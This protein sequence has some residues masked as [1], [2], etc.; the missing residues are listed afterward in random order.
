MSSN[1]TNVQPKSASSSKA[2]PFLAMFRCPWRY[3]LPEW[4]RTMSLKDKAVMGDKVGQLV[5]EGRVEDAIKHMQSFAG[6]QRH[7]LGGGRERKVANSD[8]CVV[9]ALAVVKVVEDVRR[10]RLPPAHRE[11]LPY[12]PLTSTFFS[13]SEVSPNPSNMILTAAQRAS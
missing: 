4:A 7:S 8:V 12:L 13:P 5:S 1:N 10:H 2:D 3:K 6:R 9:E 11:H